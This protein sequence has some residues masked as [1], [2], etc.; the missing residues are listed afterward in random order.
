M[1]RNLKIKLPGQ[2]ALKKFK[3]NSSSFKELKQELAGQIDFN[4]KRVIIRET[5]LTLQHDQ[6][7]LPDYDFMLFLQPLKVKSGYSYEDIRHANY[8]ELRKMC[9]EVA[10]KNPKFKD[11]YLKNSG[12]YGTV[13]EMRDALEMGTLVDDLKEKLPVEVEEDTQTID[14][15]FAKLSDQEIKDAL[16]MGTLIVD[17]KEKVPVDIQTIDSI[18][19]KLSDSIE[20]FVQFYIEKAKKQIEELVENSDSCIEDNIDTI[21]KDYNETERKLW[22]ENIILPNK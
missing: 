5:K 16:E 2:A 14:S 4:E 22:R 6:A 12:S 13:N 3:I 9:K 10:S 11:L 20:K 7:V 1:E 21:E 19:T 15:I 17:F 18:F 8:H